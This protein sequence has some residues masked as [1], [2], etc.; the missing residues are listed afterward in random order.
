MFFTLPVILVTSRL[1]VH[2]LFSSLYRLWVNSEEGANALQ[3]VR[4]SAYVYLVCAC[5]FVCAFVSSEE[6]A[7]ALQQVRLSAYVYCVCVRMCVCVC[8]CVCVC[9]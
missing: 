5:V 4:L 9:L 2:L 1:L 6:G 7:N 8:A 3:Q